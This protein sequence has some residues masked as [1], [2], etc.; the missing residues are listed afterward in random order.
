MELK[1]MKTEEILNLYANILQEL[2]DRHVVR[3]Y[4]S[5]VG[6]YAEWLVSKRMGLSLAPN[7]EKGYDA[8]GNGIRYQVKSR[9]EHQKI[10]T[11]SRILGAIRDYGGENFDYIIVLFF[12][13]KFNVKE[14]YQIPRELVKIYGRYDKHKNCY[15]LVVNNQLLE[16]SR[17]ENLIHI[18]T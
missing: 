8:V 1:E 18:F 5:P 10:G 12:D 16:D 4:N 15:V 7:S 11:G 13:R 9:W 2:N 17:V 3:T 6:D 14:A